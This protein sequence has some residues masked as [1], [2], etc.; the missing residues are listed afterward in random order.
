MRYVVAQL[1]SWRV[2]HDA[3]GEVR[4]TEKGKEEVL[5]F[6][7]W[8]GNKTVDRRHHSPKQR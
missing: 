2:I 1:D 6:A 4:R 5:A 8:Q 3:S 7:K